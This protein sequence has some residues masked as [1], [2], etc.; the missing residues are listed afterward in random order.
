MDKKIK[1]ISG[2]V[3]GKLKVVEFYD[4]DKI[5]KRTKWK[6]Q[7]ECGK[8]VVVDLK[9]LMS[10]NSKSC[11]CVGSKKISDRNKKSRIYNINE[12]YFDDVDSEEKAYFLGFIIGDG[13]VGKNTIKISLHSKDIE[14]LEKF[15]LSISSNSPI[16]HF[17]SR[18]NQDHVLL[19]C[20]SEKL[21]QKLKSLGIL[22]DKTISIGSFNINQVPDVL[23]RHFM[24]GLFDA[25]GN[26]F[27]KN[28]S[29]S[30]CRFSIIGNEK[31]LLKCQLKMMQSINIKQT[32]LYRPRISDKVATMYYSG[33]NNICK[34]FDYLYKDS[35][36]FLSRKKE[37]FVKIIN[38]RVIN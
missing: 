18:C 26:I 16:K 35:T 15:K 23:F 29:R 22:N 6:C 17:K 9:N 5:K 12:Q 2:R 28:K 31:F 27:I 1:D 24:R 21:C 13:F 36:V 8:E 3:F 4:R 7:C 20:C 37:Y 32:K 25:D 11:G 10:G 34:I 19:N 14:I 33:M 38:N 30:A